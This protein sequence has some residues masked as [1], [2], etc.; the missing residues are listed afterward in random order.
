MK[1]VASRLEKYVLI[2]LKALRAH[3]YEQQREV[4]EA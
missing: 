2:M 1:S 3:F 4:P